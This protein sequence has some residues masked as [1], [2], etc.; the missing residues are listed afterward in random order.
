MNI[1]KKIMAIS[2]IFLFIGSF[3]IPG[4]QG[5]PEG[6]EKR[7]ID[8]IES[9]P[10]KVLT[11]DETIGDRNV[12][13]W[14]HVIDDTQVK[15]DYILL[16]QDPK[17]NTIIKYEKIW[18]EVEKPI[19]NPKDET[20]KPNDYFWK[21]KVIFLEKRDCRDF[22]TFIPPQEYPFVCW[23][24]RHTD[25]TT[26]MYNLE[27]EQIGYGIQAPYK[28]FSLSGFHEPSYPDPWLNWRLNAD[29]WFS[30]WC[31]ST[32]SITHPTPTIITSYI[33]DPEY[34]LFY[35][36]AHG[37]SSYF[38]ADYTGSYYYASDVTAALIERD[39]MRFAFIGS[40]GGMDQTGPGHWSYE[41]RKGEI[42]ETVV[43]GYTGM[44]TCPGWSVSIPWQ[45]DMFYAMDAGYKIKD[46][47]D[48]AS[49]NYPTIAPCVVFT[50]DPELLIREPTG[51][52]DDDD[53]DGGNIPPRVTITYPEGY[54]TI[55]G[56]INITGNA[57]DLD[58]TVKE[59]FIQI[60]TNDWQTVEGITSWYYLWDTTKVEDGEH[61]ITA[62][63]NDGHDY[64]GC[65]SREIYVKNNETNEPEGRFP[66]LDGEGILSWSDIKPRLVVTGEFTI[67]NI[68]DPESKLH[69]EITEKPNWGDWTFS[70][71]E[72]LDLTPGDGEYTIDVIVVA[73]EEKEKDFTGN[74]KVINK[75]ENNDY[76]TI[77]VSLSTTKNKEFELYPLFIRFLEQHPNIFPIIRYFLLY[78]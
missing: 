31:E 36:L 52:D 24:V 15:N 69:W 14:L 1:T 47:F 23:E 62:I 17:T 64:S 45:D 18:R 74:I 8:I 10:D 33:S 59:V 70:P 56:T 22:Y 30:K 28:G 54:E 32:V 37:G 63:C 11:A 42:L 49:A 25:G 57:H 78:L 75:Y 13:Y 71:N 44:A 20:F 4:I 21:M 46:A 6:N 35:E 19:S 60:D 16:H 43:V 55:N 5:D 50:G 38:Q 73:P 68:G 72:G 12:K 77:P 3:I 27:G 41:F 26:I 40:C 2:I 29:S 7:I 65:V 39:P 48:I 53:E 9:I 58:G 61:V 67:K 51:D 66:D 76:I 34:G